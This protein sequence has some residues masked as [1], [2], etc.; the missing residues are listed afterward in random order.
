MTCN[1][2][3]VSPVLVPG[4]M[5]GP[6]NTHSKQSHDAILSS[7][8]LNTSNNSWLQTWNGF[9]IHMNDLMVL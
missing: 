5:G 9:L 4:E 1:V 2:L 7:Y 6:G 3:A 8:R